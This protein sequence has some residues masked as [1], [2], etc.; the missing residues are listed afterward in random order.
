MAE[1]FNEANPP[2]TEAAKLG[3]QRMRGIKAMLN[4][5]L[6]LIYSVSVSDSEIATV[7]PVASCIS[8]TMLAD[9]SVSTVK[10]A[11]LGVT[12]AKIADG[13]V[14]TSKILDENVTADKIAPNAVTTVKILAANVT[15]PKIADDAITQAKIAD[16]EICPEHFIRPKKWFRLKRTNIAA[17]DLVRVSTTVTATVSAHGLSV[18]DT[19]VIDG[20]G[21]GAF[22]ITSTILTVPTVDTFTY[23]QGSGAASNTGTGGYLYSYAGSSRSLSGASATVSAARTLTVVTVTWTAHGLVQNDRVRMS[24]S[25]TTAL[26]GEFVISYISAD[27]FSYTTSTTGAIGATT[28]TGQKLDRDVISFTASDPAARATMTSTWR[29]GFPDL[30]FCVVASAASAN[31]DYDYNV[32]VFVTSVTVLTMY[33]NQAG[34]SD[35]DVDLPKQLSVLAFS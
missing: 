35:T 28:M 8:T 33:F 12:T 30:D 29:T 20:T 22:D 14:I 24:G 10:I 17:G 26:N 11:A 16:A 32:N 31:T 23:T 19:V 1:I 3:A 27:S 25:A 7:S 34:G 21:S 13:N 5:T 2:N 15:G 6:G 18:G 4:N 9:S